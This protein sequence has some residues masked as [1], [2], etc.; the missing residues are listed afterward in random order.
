MSKQHNEQSTKRSDTQSLPR[1]VNQLGEV[2]SVA[3]DL[4]VA[5][6]VDLESPAVI[7]FQAGLTPL[8]NVCGSVCD[9]TLHSVPGSPGRHHFG[10][11]CPKCLRGLMEGEWSAVNTRNTSVHSESSDR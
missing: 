10:I 2:V 5:V 8:H 6:S 9:Y 7:A 1:V 3:D 11:V 4:L